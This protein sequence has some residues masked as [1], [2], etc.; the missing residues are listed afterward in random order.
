MCTNVCIYIVAGRG[1]RGILPRAGT[2][3]AAAAARQAHSRQLLLAARLQAVL[4][5]SLLH[6]QG[7]R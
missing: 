6:A 5:G 2:K 4:Q 3:R 7:G 1:Q